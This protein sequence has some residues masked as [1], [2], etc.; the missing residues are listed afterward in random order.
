MHK[1]QSEKRKSRLRLWFGLFCLV[2]AA[3]AG[4]GVFLCRWDPRAYRPQP[5]EN[6][7]Q[8]SGYLTHELGPD[9]INQVQ[10]DN[11]FDLIVRQDGLN[12]IISRGGWDGQFDD[13]AFTDPVI[14]FDT[15]TIYL[16]GTLD[17]KGLAS[18]LTII[19]A[20]QMNDEGLIHLNIRSIRLGM[21]PVTTLVKHL[22]QKAFRQSQGQ[23]DD[24]RT[25]EII[26]A[27]IEGRP[28]EPVFEISDRPVR[29][30]DMTIDPGQLR[31]RFRP[32]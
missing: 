7:E 10:L 29:I 27:V 3:L 13:F 23:F 25:E 20:P 24:P 21:M 26:R 2:L 4:G 6:P 8:V 9:F 28:F 32:E 18:V 19:A 14:I 12:D 16:M 22:A 15:D 11:P 17:Y 5:V 30:T 1:N 31:L